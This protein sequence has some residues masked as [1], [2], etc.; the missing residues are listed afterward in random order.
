MSRLSIVRESAVIKTARIL[1]M[2][3]LF[4]VPLAEKSRQE[5]TIEF[6][7]PETWHVGVIVG[8]SGSGK[9]TLAKT[10]WPAQMAHSF[11]WDAH[12]SV[13]D[14]FPATLSIKDV[15]QLL[16]SVGF[17]SPP[18]W[19][20]P[21]QVLSTGEQFRV[22]LARV[23]AEQSSLAV[24]DEFTS[25]VDRTVAQIGSAALAKT[26][27]RRQ[28]QFVAVTCHYDVLDWLE[29]D[30]VYDMQN[31][32]MHR[33]TLWR[34]PTLAI[35]ICRVHYTAWAYFRPY[36]YLNTECNKASRCF[37]G[38]YQDRP[39]AFVA[40][41][42][43]PL[44]RQSNIK[45]GHRTVVLPDYQGMGIGNSMSNYIASAC[46]ALGYRYLSM[47]SH[48]SMMHTRLRSGVWRLLSK[49]QLNAK[50]LPGRP[51]LAQQGS[52]RSGHLATRLTATFE[53]IGPS[54]ALSD[55]R[56]IWEN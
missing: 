15:V 18:L 20:R 3:S 19:V 49:P 39:V 36:H 14:M 38:W 46:K 10:L 55:A 4:D 22:S 8:P 29:P 11:S 32:I 47:T 48:P 40:V 9:T 52:G 33:G 56:S 50:T 16:T 13:L 51:M 28:Q 5:W 6:D 30:W 1:Q 25:V 37:V 7:L 23:L 43:F 27:R 12:K 41:Q 2:A 24:M 34:R 17:A 42:H 21:F 44:P 26:V 53:Y 45:R 35:D 54:L 31:H